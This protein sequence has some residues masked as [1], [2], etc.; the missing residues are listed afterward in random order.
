[1]TDDERM[2]RNPAVEIVAVKLGD[3]PELKASDLVPN[4]VYILHSPRYCAS[5]NYLGKVHA[6]DPRTLDAIVLHHFF[7]PRIGLNT[8]LHARPDGA[9][10]DQSGTRI[11][12]RKYTG[13]DA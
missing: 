10:E 4:H 8:H 9:L 11:V 6:L 12:I 5:L 3:C 2:N 13:P 7:A 1:M